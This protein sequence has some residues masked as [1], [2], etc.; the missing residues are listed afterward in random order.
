MLYPGGRHRAQRLAAYDLLGQR[1][2]GDDADFVPGAFRRLAEQ[3]A[4]VHGPSVVIS[5]EE[6]GL[7]RPRHVRRVAR[8]LGRH[9]LHVVVGVRDIARTAVSAWQQNI[10]T[11]STTPWPE[12]IAAVRDR[13]VSGVPRAPPRSGSATTS[14]ACWTLGAR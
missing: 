11:G 5:E 6:L 8:S 12:F 14:S 10:M 13:R 7:A 4:C 1:V 2:R 3:V 9:Q